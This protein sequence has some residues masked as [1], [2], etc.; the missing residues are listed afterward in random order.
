MDGPVAQSLETQ[1]L[2]QRANA[3]Y[4]NRQRN[5][6]WTVYWGSA[7]VKTLA[8]VAS[9]ILGFLV[10][11]QQA[12]S[13]LTAIVGVAIPFLA[14]LDAGT[15]ASTN[16]AAAEAHAQLAIEFDRLHTSFA[17]EGSLT[18]DQAVAARAALYATADRLAST[19]YEPPGAYVVQHMAAAQ[20]RRLAAAV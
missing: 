7:I 12:P 19:Y 1:T 18:L 16:Q 8:L 9:S 11:G 14:R 10:E 17:L 5:V 2:L 6:W 4:F 3:A 20:S 13:I 15:S